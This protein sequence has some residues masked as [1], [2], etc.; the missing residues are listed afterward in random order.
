MGLGV[1]LIE[2]HQAYDFILY[3]LFR[4]Q[5]ASQSSCGAPLPKAR[6]VLL[7]SS[8]SPDPD[9]N[10]TENIMLRCGNRGT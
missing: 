1:S 8:G 5:R 2:R 10:D 3:Q 4:S 9:W 7:C 6:Y